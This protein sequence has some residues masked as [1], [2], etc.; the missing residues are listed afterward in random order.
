MWCRRATKQGSKAVCCV[1]L[2]THTPSLGFGVIFSG[3]SIKGSGTP[4]RLPWKPS[5]L[6]TGPTWRLVNRDAAQLFRVK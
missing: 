4:R 6:G 1:A 5:V 3:W 2:G